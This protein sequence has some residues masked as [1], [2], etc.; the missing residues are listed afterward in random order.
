VFK[1][2]QVRILAISVDKPAASRKFAKAYNLNFPLIEDKGL[3]LARQYVGVDANGYSLPGM[4][5][6]APDRTIALRK[7]G[8]TPGDRLYAA[9]LLEIVDRIAAEHRL[10]TGNSQ[11]AGGFAPLE[12]TNL[13]LGLTLGLLQQRA[14]QNTLGFSTDLTVAG[15]Y[16]LTRH[17]MLGAL[18]RGLTGSATR[19][20]IDAAL[21]LRLPIIDDNGEFYAQIPLGVSI[22]VSNDAADDHERTGWNTGLAVGMQ[23]APKPS[24][25]IF[26]ELEGMYHRF[27]GRGA[28]DQHI[29]LRYQ[30]GGGVAWLF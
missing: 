29:E 12:R 14:Q 2:R 10:P 22:D 7:I 19:A 15:L 8:E 30:A 25:G 1:D 23:F 13:R 26:L 18:A 9:D 24:L 16:P 28:L 27:A 17:V 6:I 3:V 5:I 4:I 21:R 20:D 11:L